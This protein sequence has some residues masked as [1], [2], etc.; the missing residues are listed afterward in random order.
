[1]NQLEMHW[2]TAVPWDTL[3][4]VNQA[5]CQAKQ[6][7]SQQNEKTCETARQLWESARPRRMPLREV[8]DVCRECSKLTPFV[9]NNGNT[10]AAVVKTLLEDPLKSMPPV[11]AQ[12]IR[13]TVAHYVNGL[14]G[15]KELLQVLRHFEVAWEKPHGAP[16][17]SGRQAEQRFA[18]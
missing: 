5:L 8:L 2:L 9:F 16:T 3:L 10:F 14:V 13:T 1:M 18:G 6:V 12:I 11:E 15:K 17:P 4:T 7:T